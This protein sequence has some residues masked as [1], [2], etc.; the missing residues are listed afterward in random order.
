M[1]KTKLLS[2]LA[3]LLTMVTQGA[4]ADNEVTIATNVS[5]QQ[6]YTSRDVTVTFSDDVDGYGGWILSN[7][8]MTV[9]VNNGIIKSVV[10]RIGHFAEETETVHTSGNVGT[11]TISPKTGQEWNHAEDEDDP[12]DDYIYFYEDG[13]TWVTFS[14]IN[15]SSVNIISGDNWVQ[16]D[17]VKV[18][19]TDLVAV[20]GVSLSQTEAT[21]FT[22][23]TVT[24]TPTVAPSNALY[25]NVTWSTSNASVATVADGVVTAVGAGTATITVTATNGT[26]DTSDDKTAT[27]TVTVSGTK[28]VKS[29][30][31]KKK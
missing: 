15:T 7:L 6:S 14:D 20:T 31:A 19:Y 5:G 8:P 28:K 11:R 23:G 29:V 1:R 3:L 27:C 2:I 13:N 9:S 18:T 10:V 4:W 30:K 21:L 12:D 17:E 22:G 24:L 26:D 16:I 25:K